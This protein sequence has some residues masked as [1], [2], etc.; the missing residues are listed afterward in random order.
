MGRTSF[1]SRPTFGRPSAK[2]PATPSSCAWT[3]ASARA[4][5]P[6]GAGQAVLRARRPPAG[7]GG[8]DPSPARGGD[9]IDVDLLKEGGVALVAAV[10]RVQRALVAAQ[11]RGGSSCRGV[12]ARE[13]ERGQSE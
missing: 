2:P 7:A 11:R 8:G 12:R 3:S 9:V 13:Q 10:Q 4:S 5:G 1:P 6:L